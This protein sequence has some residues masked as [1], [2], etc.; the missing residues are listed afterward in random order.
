MLMTPRTVR[1]ALCRGDVRMAEQLLLENLSEHVPAGP[2][3]P[4]CT[5][6][7]FKPQNEAPFAQ[8][9]LLL[10]WSCQYGLAYAVH[11]LLHLLRSSHMQEKECWEPGDNLQVR[12]SQRMHHRASMG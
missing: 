12:A 8:R 4:S 9:R 2:P 3:S 5:T 11:E 6:L 10:R 1:E 7:A